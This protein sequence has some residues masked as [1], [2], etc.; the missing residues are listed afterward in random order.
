[1]CL[2]LVRCVRASECV[3]EGC[4]TDV[5]ELQKCYTSIVEDLNLSDFECLKYSLSKGL[6]VGIVVGGSIVKLP[7]LLLSTR[8]VR[9][10]SPPSKTDTSPS[11]VRPLRSRNLSD[12]LHSRNLLLSRNMRVLISQ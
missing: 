1:M 4:S 10:I 8:S 3:S 7:Q 5:F 11:P 2:S 9:G 12:L 6:G